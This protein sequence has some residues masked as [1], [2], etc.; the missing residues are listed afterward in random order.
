RSA[1]PV[2]RAPQF[3][4]LGRQQGREPEEARERLPR[5]HVERARVGGRAQVEVTGQVGER[6]DVVAVAVELD[7]HHATSFGSSPTR[8]FHTAGTPGHAEA[9]SFDGMVLSSSR[10]MPRLSASSKKRARTWLYCSPPRPDLSSDGLAQPALMSAW[11]SM[12]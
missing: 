10:S 11:S 12:R 1:G 7:G 4:E 9:L 5:A 3:G 8:A 2:V 6:G